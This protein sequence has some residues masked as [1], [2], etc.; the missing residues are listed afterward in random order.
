M[1]FSLNLVRSAVPNTTSLVRNMVHTRIQPVR[2]TMNDAMM[3]NGIVM[4]ARSTMMPTGTMAVL[5]MLPS[6]PITAIDQM[7]MLHV[8]PRLFINHYTTLIRLGYGSKRNRM[9]SME[10]VVPSLELFNRSTTLQSARS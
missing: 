7:G 1:N 3:L 6:M 10:A 2:S 5:S 8:V 4:I 9:V